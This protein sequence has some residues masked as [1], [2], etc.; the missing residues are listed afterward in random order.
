MRPISPTWTWSGSSPRPAYQSVTLSTYARSVGQYTAHTRS[1]AAFPGLREE[2]YEFIAA[3]DVSRV[4]E[5]GV[6]GGRDFEELEA[7]GGDLVV[8]SD[9]CLEFL[10][11]LDGARAACDVQALPFR[12]ASFTAIWCC[13]VLVHL[14]A[15]DAAI[16][17]SEIRRA[18]RPGGLA[19]IS[20]KTGPGPE[21]VAETSIGARWIRHYEPDELEQITEDA[22]LEVVRVWSRDVGDRTW[23]TVWATAAV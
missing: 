12:D 5:V 16:A 17:M 8:A 14:A 7:A 23:L 3:A 9:A 11:Q 13:A 15:A 20:V 2:L 1:F 22:G 18:L 4:L 19:A 21:G 10:H 6:G